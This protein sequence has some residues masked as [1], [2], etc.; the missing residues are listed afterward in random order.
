M[1][2]LGGLVLLVL[3]GAAAVLGAAMALAVLG[4]PVPTGEW[5]D[6]MRPFLDRIAV[7]AALPPGSDVGALIV[8]GWGQV[9]VAAIASGAVIALGGLRQMISGRRS[10]VFLVLVAA[11]IVGFAVAGALA[12]AEAF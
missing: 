8:R 10:V 4:R 3:G 6:W 1:V 12:P 5:I 2:R 7:K 11:I 9:A